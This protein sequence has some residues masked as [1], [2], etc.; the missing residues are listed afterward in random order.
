MK[1]AGKRKTDA[2]ADALSRAWLDASRDL[3]IEVVS[4]FILESMGQRLQYPMLIKHFGCAKGTLLV[5]VG[6]K[7]EELL[8]ST[9]KLEGYYCSKV[10]TGL[11]LVYNAESF[12]DVLNDWGWFGPNNQVPQWY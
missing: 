9:A 5:I 8:A 10:N 2:D 12:K 1:E 7:D 6:C 3:G 11:D 4:P